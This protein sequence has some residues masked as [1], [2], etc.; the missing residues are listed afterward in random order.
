MSRASFGVGGK[1]RIQIRIDIVVVA[2]CKHAGNRFG[3]SEDGLT[4]FHRDTHYF[5]ASLFHPHLLYPVTYIWNLPI[6]DA[7]HVPHYVS[8]ASLSLPAVG[9]SGHGTMYIVHIV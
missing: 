9:Y 5:G 1:Q 8:H 2:C 7:N 4:R 6:I 3:G